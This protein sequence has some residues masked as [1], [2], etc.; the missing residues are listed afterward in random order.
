MPIRR[1]TYQRNDY[2]FRPW[3]TDVDLLIE[4]ENVMNN[5]RNRIGD[6]E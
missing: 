4:S 6:N 3:V 5:I 2:Y 1:L